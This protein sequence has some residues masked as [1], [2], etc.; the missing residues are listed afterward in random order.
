MS[1]EKSLLMKGNLIEVHA[2]KGL[3][4]TQRIEVEI[5]GEALL[6]AMGE[7]G[8]EASLAELWV[9]EGQLTQAQLTYQTSQKQGEKWTCRECGEIN[10]SAFELCWQCG[11]D[12][13]CSV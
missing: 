12:N 11:T 13:P 2:L 6:G 7:F 8:M 5:R 3:L 4:E 10:E 1:S 9:N